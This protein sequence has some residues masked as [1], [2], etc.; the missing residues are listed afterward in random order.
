MLTGALPGIRLKES[1]M[2][3]LA[4]CL[5]LACLAT[6]V[7]AALGVTAAGAAPQQGKHGRVKSGRVILSPRPGTL[8]GGNTAR[9]AVRSGPGLRI[10]LNRQWIPARDLGR[11]RHGVRRLQLSISYGLRPG[12][13]YL[14]VRV[15]KGKDA[16]RAAIHFRVQSRVPLLGAGTDE[17]A[18]TGDVVQLSGQT[19]AAGGGSLTWTPVTVPEDDSPSCGQPQSSSELRSPEGLSA[20]FTPTVPGR[21]VYRLT[22]GSG[23]DRI[24]DSNEVKVVEPNHMVPVETIIDT[25]PDF[26][27]TGI[28][29][30]KINYLLSEAKVMPEASHSELQV[31]VLKRETLECVTNRRYR[32]AA[33][34]GDYLKTLNVSDLVIVAMQPGASPGQ[35]DGKALYS[36]LGTIGF[37]KI[38]DEIMPTI[39]GS[40]S[41]IGVWG[42]PR[43]DANVNVLPRSSALPAEPAWMTGNL[44]PDQH[45]NFDFSPSLRKPFDFVPKAGG[46]CG[47]KHACEQN[48]GYLLRVLDKRTGKKVSEHF[49]ATGLT[50]V[51]ELETQDL[52]KAIESV[53]AG[54][55]VELVSAA[56]RTTSEADFPPPML[57]MKQAT[58]DKLVNAVTG[59][60]GTRNAFNRTSMT[61]GAA[62]SGGQTY[63]LVGWQGAKE[64]EGAE[65]AAGVFGQGPAPVLHGELRPDRQSLLRPT[66]ES[67]ISTGLNLPKVMLWEP[68]QKWPLEGNA[69]AMKAFSFLG[70]KFPGKLGAEPRTSYWELDLE[71]SKWESMAT[72]IEKVA[73]DPSFKKEGFNKAEF[74][75]ARGELTDELNWVA[76]A[77]EYL[78]LLA[79][80]FYEEQFKSWADVQAIGQKIYGDAEASNV[81]TSFK[82]VELTSIL[83]KLTGPLTA[84]V[85]STFAQL[86][87]LEK[88]AYGSNPN[89]LPSYDSVELKTTELATELM[90]QMESGAKTYGAMLDVIVSDPKKLEK[91]GKLG[92]CKPDTKECGEFA[93]TKHEREQVTADLSRSIQRLAYEKLLPTSFNVYKTNRDPDPAAV[94]GKPRNAVDYHC[95]GYFHPWGN[96]EIRVRPWTFTALLEEQDVEHD[97]TLNNW[98]V[99]AIGTPGRPLHEED[100]A[101]SWKILNRMFS[102]VPPNT[103][104]NT[105]ADGIG[106]GMSSEEFLANQR[107]WKKWDKNPAPGKEED[108]CSW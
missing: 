49:Y 101:P 5:A 53:P 82:W 104:P 66:L 73:W 94:G 6:T 13:N 86:L 76:N 4:V 103:D 22:S 64:G 100:H 70:E 23:A 96:Y 3:R 41:G 55:V 20:S 67:D 89:G 35:V 91:I 81:N 16:R 40:F 28:R 106:L 50:E 27:K 92:N 88:W 11:A 75:E 38:D 59:L 105:E 36:A 44:L 68:V 46:T 102:P 21:Y 8:V 29:V 10:R 37:P 9:L 52:V 99:L 12:R 1:K 2:R 42:M 31:V 34:L 47:D 14:T 74:L 63:V 61:R 84:Q 78:K 15:G 24:T 45:S 71:P 17:V 108:L 69:G 83:L 19:E 107:P 43:G 32:S 39:G 57:A 18:G 26:A 85:T 95:D 7:V 97:G 80:P 51:H 79:E 77:G 30:G 56:R 60:G 65:V 48:T 93:F 87:D 33:E 58:Y 72:A 90:R 25:G 54:E 98:Q 62:A